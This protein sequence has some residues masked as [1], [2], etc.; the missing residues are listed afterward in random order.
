MNLHFSSMYVTNR[1]VDTAISF[2]ASQKIVSEYATEDTFAVLEAVKSF[3][4]QYSGE[5]NSRHCQS[6]HF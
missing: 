2:G 6:Q 4:T 5:G 1:I 3:V